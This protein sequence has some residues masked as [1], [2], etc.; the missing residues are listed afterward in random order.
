MQIDATVVEFKQ[1]QQQRRQEQQEVVSHEQ[2]QQEQQE[3]IQEE[4]HAQVLAV[5][6]KLAQEAKVAIFQGVQEQCEA[7]AVME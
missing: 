4:E 2:Q 6:Q 7:M 5:I 3:Q 1:A